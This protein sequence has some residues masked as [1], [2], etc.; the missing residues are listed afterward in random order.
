MLCLPGTLCEFM[1]AHMSHL[2]RYFPSIECAPHGSSD[3]LVDE[4]SL[5]QPSVLLQHSLI[6]CLT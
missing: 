5:R 2:K 4:L 6:L 3:G 1:K